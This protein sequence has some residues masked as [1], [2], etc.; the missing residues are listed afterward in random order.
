MDHRDSEF[1]VS[2]LFSVPR[3]CEL[4]AELGSR[5]GY[6][7]DLV[8]KEHITGQRWNFSRLQ[9]RSRLWNLLRQKM[10][11]LLVASPPCKV[12]SVLQQ[13]SPWTIGKA[14]K[15]QQAKDHM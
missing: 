12:F 8:H 1:D 6:S 2:E 4:A 3:S 15:L 14:K 10:S 7:L 11:K 9:E 13:L 5:S